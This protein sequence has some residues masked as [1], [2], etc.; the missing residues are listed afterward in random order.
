MISVI[1]PVYK[2]QQRIRQTLENLR[3]LKEQHLLREVL[4]VQCPG[5]SYDLPTLTSPDRGRAA[6]MNHGAAQAGGEI[7]LFLHADTILPEN[8]LPIIATARAGA[9]SLRFDSPRLIF[10]LIGW[11]TTMRSRLLRLPY[12][13]QA[14][15]LPR[16]DFLRA[17]GYADVPILEDVLLTRKIRPRVL[18]EC[19]L[20]SIRRYEKNGVIG[21]ILRHRLIM[22][23]F[24]LG[25]G[26]ERLARH[27]AR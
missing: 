27:V 10:N 4:I 21:T 1:I 14:I 8:A 26:P 16:P 22:L 23:G 7:L 11:L 13:D 19:V 24:T 18:P 17:G 3:T 6:Q 20:T 15:F 25:I 5:E 12:G 2:E 9:F